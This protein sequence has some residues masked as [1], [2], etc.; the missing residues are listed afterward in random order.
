M[1]NALIYVLSGALQRLSF[2]FVIP[3]FTRIL[4]E[5]DFG[6]YVFWISIYSLLQTFLGL[7]VDAAINRLYFDYQLNSNKTLSYLSTV[8]GFQWILVLPLSILF[9]FVCYIVFFL[10][11]DGLVLLP[12]LPLVLLS[13]SF[14]KILESVLA[15]HRAARNPASYCFATL[16]SLLSLSSFFGLFLFCFDL[17][18]IGVFAAL[19]LSN[20]VSSAFATFI[21]LK[22]S[23]FRFFSLHYIRESFAYGMP[24]LP[25][26]IG[27]WI[28]RFSNKLLIVKFLSPVAL[29]QF[30]IASVPLSLITLF[31]VS[32]N[33]AYVP[34][35]YSKALLLDPNNAINENPRYA[36]FISNVK[37]IDACLLILYAL[38]CLPFLFFPETIVGILAPIDEYGDS[39]RYLPSLAFSAFIFCQYT[40]WNRFLTFRKQTSL[41]SCAVFLPGIIC[42][43]LNAFF[44]PF[45]GLLVPALVSV[46]G[47]WLSYVLVFVFSL[48]KCN[49]APSFRSFFWRL[50]FFDLIVILLWICP[51]TAYPSSF[52][53]FD[54]FGPYLI[55]SF[56]AFLYCAL[57][58]SLFGNRF[59][60]EL[61]RRL[62]TLFSV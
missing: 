61:S 48:R 30:Q 41:S 62:S 7:G 50:Q 2:L 5:E 15:A 35:F 38:T 13:A 47:S 21:L 44:M 58:F 19:V 56:P 26:K 23:A 51:W 33:N 53:G 28:S 39:V 40:L 45:H 43:V 14:Q 57:I 36:K 29:S 6:I 9:G 25:G 17:G 8:I 59:L 3:L 22:G 52:A 20:F 10:F 32:M 12:F 46:L 49:L 42:V 31:A 4:S 11:F 24:T 55:R 60:A 34:W 1:K 27:G 18:L 16:I 54:S 37:D